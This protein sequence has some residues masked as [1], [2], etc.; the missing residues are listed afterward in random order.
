LKATATTIRVIDLYSL[1]PI[2]AKSLIAGGESHR[3]PPD[4][5]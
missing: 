1:A 4:H 5:G 2:D 3:R